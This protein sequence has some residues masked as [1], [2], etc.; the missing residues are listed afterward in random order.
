MNLSE[1]YNQL[2]EIIELLQY[3]ILSHIIMR[4][5]FV[6]DFYPVDKQSNVFH[7]TKVIHLFKNTNYLISCDNILIARD[8]LYHDFKNWPPG[9]HHV[10]RTVRLMFSCVW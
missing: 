1:N 5:M 7:S 8:K 2:F 10:A 6:T 4:L 3:H 9:H